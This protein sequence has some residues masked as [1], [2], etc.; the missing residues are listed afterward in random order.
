MEGRPWL[1]RGAAVVMEEYDGFSDVKAIKLDRIPVWARIQGM[2]EGLMKKKELAEKVAKKVGDLITVVVTDGK[3]NSTLFLRIRVWLDLKKPLVR[4]VPIMLKE[5]MKY[6]VQYE[7]LPSF[8]FYCG[9]LGHEV[10][11]CGDGVHPKESWDWGDWLRVPFT[12][13]VP[14]RDDRGGRGRG[15][16]RGRGGSGGRGGGVD[17]ELYDMEIPTDND[18]G[19]DQDGDQNMK[20]YLA[21]EG[22]TELAPKANVSPL[23]EQDKKRPRTSNQNV[24]VEKENPNVRSALSFEESDRAQ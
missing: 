16:G 24:E 3:I 18:E 13:L 22:S 6:L 14:V 21:I 10:S 11:E 17:E 5:R 9:C 23:P 19:A 8:C 7:K 20:G 12:A 4:V 15:R 1:F 2:P